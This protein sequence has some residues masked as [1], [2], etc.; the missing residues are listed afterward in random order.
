MRTS[1]K[2]LIAGRLTLQVLKSP[3]SI[4]IRIMPLRLAQIMPIRILR[5]LAILPMLTIFLPNCSGGR[6]GNHGARRNAKMDTYALAGWCMHVRAE[7]SRTKPKT[8]YKKDII[9]HTCSKCGGES[10]FCCA[11][12]P[13]GGKTKGM[14][15]K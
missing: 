3:A 14:E 10:A 15:E 1:A 5:A 4:T 6:H 7:A 8:P 2:N 12:K 11:T 13:G 9:T